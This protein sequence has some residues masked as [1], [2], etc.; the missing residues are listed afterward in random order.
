ML[1]KSILTISVYYLAKLKHLHLVKL[2]MCLNVFSILL[3]FSLCSLISLFP[4]S[5]LCFG[6][7]TLFEPF[8]VFYSN[9][10]VTIFNTI[11]SFFSGCSADYKI[12]TFYN[13]FIINI[14]SCLLQYRNHN[15]IKFPLP[16]PSLC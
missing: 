6:G 4:L 1:F 8:L 11:Y 3:L 9:L 13:I 10:S 7:G 16:C 12:H 5:C 14:L 2:M 15:T